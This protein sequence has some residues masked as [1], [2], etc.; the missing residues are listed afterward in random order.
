MYKNKGQ[1]KPTSWAVAF[2]NIHIAP[3]DGSTDAANRNKKET[4]ADEDK[5]KNRVHDASAGINKFNLE[6]PFRVGDGEVGW[7]DLDPDRPAERG[8]HSRD[9]N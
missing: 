8:R 9:A 3:S 5:E 7:G 1:T 2:F 6:I 4:K